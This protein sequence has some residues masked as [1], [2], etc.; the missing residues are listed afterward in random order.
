MGY[1]K[2]QISEILEAPELDVEEEEEEKPPEDPEIPVEP[3]ESEGN[4][5]IVQHSKGWLEEYAANYDVILNTIQLR[6]KNAYEKFIK[7]MR[8]SA[9]RRLR[10]GLSPDLQ[11]QEWESYFREIITPVVKYDW[12]IGASIFLEEEKLARENS[13]AYAS[14]FHSGKAVP[15]EQILPPEQL[16]A[17]ERTIQLG[18]EKATI[19][20]SNTITKYNRQILSKVLEGASVDELRQHIIELIGPEVS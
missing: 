2:S 9:L 17:L 8:E 7:L 14:G 3:T 4:T 18:I 15:L 6:W 13:K 10:R 11:Q 1:K 16:A 20:G 5:I 12:T 19:I